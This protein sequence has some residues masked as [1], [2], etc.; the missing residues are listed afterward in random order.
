MAPTR[1][2]VIVAN[3]PRHAGAV[4]SHLSKSFQLSPPAVRF[5][6]VPGLLTPETDGDLLLLASDPADASGVETVV[7]E[8]RVQQLPARL[9]VLET[10]PVRD[11]RLLTHLTPHLTG[12]WTWPHQAKDLTAWARRALEPGTPFADPAAETV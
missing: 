1:R 6:D 2:L 5:E 10:E 8:T 3:D 7:R 9:A 11:L 12:R 4:Q